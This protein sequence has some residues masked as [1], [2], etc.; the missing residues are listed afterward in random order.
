M[1]RYFTHET[2]PSLKPGAI[3]ILATRKNMR[4]KDIGAGNST[5]IHYSTPEFFHFDYIGSDE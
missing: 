5:L 4:W 2:T 3:A 1:L